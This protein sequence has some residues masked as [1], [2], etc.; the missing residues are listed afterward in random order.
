M[1][2]VSDE[3]LAALHRR[4]ETAEHC[5]ELAVQT[6]QRVAKLLA[7]IE[8]VPGSQ[9]GQHVEQAQAACTAFLQSPEVQT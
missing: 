9:Y 4:A 5:A 3:A 6:L 2:E 1:P 7:E 8:P